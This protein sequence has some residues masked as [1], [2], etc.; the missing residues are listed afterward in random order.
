VPAAGVGRRFGGDLPKQY[1]MV[2]GATVMEHT[3]SLLLTLPQLT[4]L[5]LVVAAD[6]ERWREIALTRDPRV[7]IVAGGAERCH[8][9]R[10]GLQR[11]AETDAP[12]TVLVHDVARP[13]CPAADIER[14]I[15]VAGPHPDGGLLALPVADTLKEAA[16][17]KRSVRTVDRSRLWQAQTPQLFDRTLL[18]AALD[19]AFV[20]G[21]VV[22]DEAQA[23]EALGRR[24]LLV[25][26]SRRNLKI[27]R[28]DDLALA[29]FYLGSG[30][31]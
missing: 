8:S 9:V 28:A 19:Q 16:A 23:V 7:L 20:D 12:P 24:P 2:A 26:G 14:L 30:V 27:T 6:D 15:R 11:L 10:N 31:A 21:T 22:T 5:V 4:H 25:E 29:A 18:A 13:C 1:A 17:D 3:L